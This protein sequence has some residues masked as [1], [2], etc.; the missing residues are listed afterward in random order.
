MPKARVTNN[1]ATPVSSNPSANRTPVKIN[2][3]GTPMWYKVIM[4][5]F[6]II[7]LA[8][9]ITNYLAGED[10]AFMAQLGAWNYGIG[11]GLMI[12]GLLMTMGWR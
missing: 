8:W 9:L 3:T 4:F 1:A 5:A 7:G 6:M 11:F 2:S 12:I 10:I